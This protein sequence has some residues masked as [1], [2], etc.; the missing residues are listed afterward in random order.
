ML[1]HY[2]SHCGW[3]ARNPNPLPPNVTVPAG[4]IMP[5]GLCSACGAFAY[6]ITREMVVIE[7][8]GGVAEVALKPDHIQVVIVDHDVPVGASASESE[9]I[10]G[11]DENVQGYYKDHYKTTT[12]DDMCAIS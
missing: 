8:C 5:S 3:S 2:C 6:P 4:A 12:A 10:L 11:S 7:V 1:R 9:D